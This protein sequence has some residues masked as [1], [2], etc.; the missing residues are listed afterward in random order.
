[1]LFNW[2]LPDGSMT[3]ANN[4]SFTFNAPGIYGVCLTIST[5]DSCTSTTCDTVYV[6]ANGTITT[7]PINVDCLGIPGGPNMPGTACNDGDTLTVQ[8]TWNSACQCIGVPVNYYDC[9]QVVNGPNL[10]GTPCNDNNPATIG[11]TWDANCTCLGSVPQP[12]NADFWVLQAYTVDSVT[13]LPAPT[14]NLLWIW[15]LS[16]GGSGAFTFLW[17]FGDGTSSTD[18]F[19]THTYA[20]GGPYLLCL[21]INDS[22]GCSDTYC[23]S[24]SVDANGFYTGMLATGTDRAA[25]FSINVRDPLATGITEAVIAEDGLALWPNPVNDQLNIALTGTLSGTV[26]VQ[27]L[28]LNGRLVRSERRSLMSGRNQLQLSTADLDAGLYLLRLGNSNTTISRR[29]VKVD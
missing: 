20:N 9:L 5:A 27:V 11:D 15:N 7:S 23:D 28:D 18:P 24:V 26:D 19:P 2:W 3:T 17:S 8:D 1:M 12:C 16:S 22:L 25:G 4:P 10:P 6:D 21:T 14:P 29:F 13:N